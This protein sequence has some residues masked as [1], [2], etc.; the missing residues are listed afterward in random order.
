MRNFL[1][2]WFPYLPWGLKTLSKWQKSTNDNLCRTTAHC[3]SVVNQG[4]LHSLQV[5]HV[6][7]SRERSCGEW[8]T[9][10]LPLKEQRSFLGMWFEKTLKPGEYTVKEK[11]FFD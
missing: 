9:H 11:A 2:L 7:V 1:Y 6:S 4:E 10:S 8:H 5:Q 3:Q